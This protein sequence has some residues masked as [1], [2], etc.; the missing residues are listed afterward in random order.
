[1]YQQQQLKLDQR[2][3]ILSTISN[4]NGMSITL[5]D[6]GAT[7]LDCQVPLV[8][9]SLREV[10]L[11][12]QKRADYFTQQVYLGASVGRYANRIANASY[13]F[14][15]RAVQLSAN[16]GG[17][18]LLHGGIDGFDKRRWQ[19]KN[20]TDNSV[21][22]SLFSADGDQGFPGNLQVEAKFVL[23][24]DNSVEIC[25]RAN[26][27][28]NSPVNLTNH[29]YFNLNGYRSD[30]RTHKL[31]IDA[32]QYLP[33]DNSGIPQ[34]GLKPVVKSGFDFR[35]LKMIAQDFLKDDDQ[36][37][38][39][40]YDHSFLL[41]QHSL[42]KL[43][44]IQAQVVLCSE[45]EKLQLEVTTNQPCVQIYTGNYLAGTPDR[46]GGLY[47]DNQGIAIESQTLPDSPNHPEWKYIQ[48]YNGMLDPNET[49]LSQTIFK[50]VHK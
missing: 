3:I 8:D 11:G 9:G 21:T 13:C 2:D 35:N 38:T 41:N 25:Y 34:D 39:K 32:E 50:F 28:K 43:T 23:N 31:F 49:Y 4:N 36:K 47:E 27:D 20:Y 22:F 6:W 29:A 1:M 16:Q 30:V 17:Q 14:A 45:D 19:L 42:S 46:E 10:L 37:L 5:M 18:H 7:W 40:G 24:D 15:E 33:V 26:C 12:C 44:G 48:S